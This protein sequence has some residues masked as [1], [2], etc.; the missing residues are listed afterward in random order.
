MGVPSREAII[1]GVIN[2]VSDYNEIEVLIQLLDNFVEEDGN[3]K[4]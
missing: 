1:E 2:T 3:F 4:H